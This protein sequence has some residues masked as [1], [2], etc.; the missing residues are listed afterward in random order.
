MHT[1]VGAGGV[2][3][4]EVTTELLAKGLPVRL[5]SRRPV[6][7]FTG[8]IWQKADLK[9]FAELSAAVKG[10]T[11][12]YLCAGLKYDKRVWAAEWPLIMQNVINAAKQNKARLIFFDN[13]YMYGRVEGA[14]TETTPYNPCS[15]KGEIR[16]RIAERLLQEIKTGNLRGSIAR[17]AD[18]YGA[19]SLNSFY[20]SMVLAKYAKGQKAMWLG[21]P[22]SLHSFTYVPD[23]GK[24]MAVLGL[25][26]SS[27]GGTW[28]MPTAPARKGTAFIE[29]AASVSQC[30]P[31]YLK[32]NKRMLQALGLFNHLIGESV[33]LYYQY[34]YDYRFDSSKFEK[35]FGIQ[36][37]SYEA[38]T[39]EFAQW[40]KKGKSIEEQDLT[41]A[42]LQE[43]YQV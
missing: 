11:V 7:Q 27:D 6:T 39:S 37:T 18:F 33:E 24:A 16:A 19:Q 15:V 9:N 1:I 17:A 36:P 43:H 20:D 31:A 2:I 8:A 30:Q 28:H 5:V 41:S 42:K 32:V 34:Q 35:A 13:V 40:L 3:A 38:G 10:S 25:N 23:A 14:M 26:E 21:D 22:R 4:N 12:I 29:L